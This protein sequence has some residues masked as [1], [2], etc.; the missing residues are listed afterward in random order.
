MDATALNLSSAASTREIQDVLGGGPVAG[1]LA[2][3]FAAIVVLFVLLLREKNAHVRT[4]VAVIP[5]ADKMNATIARNTDTLAE[6]TDALD[7]ALLVV[8][9]LQGSVQTPA[10]A[11]KIAHAQPVPVPLL[12]QL[13]KKED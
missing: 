5:I 12:P 4:A 8:R 7:D 13:P 6:A 1:L 9:S 11:R 3:Q 2:I 10:R